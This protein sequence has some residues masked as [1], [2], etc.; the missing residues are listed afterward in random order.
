MGSLFGKT[1]KPQPIEMP[2]PPEVQA[3]S[4][5]AD[6][7]RQR[8]A[9]AGALAGGTLLTGPRGLSASGR[10]NSGNTLLGQ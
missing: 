4:T 6:P 10:G 7:T 8:R 2:P 5:L 9:L 1:P 3:P